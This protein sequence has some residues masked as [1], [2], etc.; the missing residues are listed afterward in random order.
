MKY[1]VVVLTEPIAEG[2][3]RLLRDE[4]REVRLA[5]NLT[6]TQLCETVSDAQ[7]IVTRLT[8]VTRKMIESAR[9]LKVVVR[10]GVGVDNID[11]EAATEHGVQVVYTPEGLSVSV[12]EFTIGTILTLLK[13]IREADAAVRGGNW[14]ARYT[15]LVGTELFGKTVGIVG[16]GRI[17]IEVAKRLRALAVELVYNDIVRQPEA[18]TEVP[19]R[20]VPLDTL[21]KRSDIVCLHVPGTKET[22]HMIGKSELAM[23]KPGAVLVNMSRGMVVDEIALTEALSSGGLDGVALDVFENE[24]LPSDSPLVQFPNVLLS[25]HMSAHTKEALERTAVEVAVAVKTALAGKTM[26]YLANP[27]V[28]KL[29]NLRR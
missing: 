19:V 17:G 27:E 16:L 2:G 13:R 10:H 18:E 28:L 6:E 5:S 11:L 4:F 29:T 25:P 21:L 7:A 24:P 23:M 3:M 26:R 8:K 1:D 14:N 22:F 15:D 12:A 9:H 20:F